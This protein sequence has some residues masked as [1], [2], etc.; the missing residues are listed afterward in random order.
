[1]QDRTIDNALLALRKQII[2]GGLEGRDQVEALL[3]LRGLPIPRTMGYPACRGCM[4]RLILDALSSGPKPLCDVVAHVV[5]GR[6]ELTGE[7]AYHRTA[8]RLYRMKLAGLVW[9]E[10]RIWFVLPALQ[11]GVV[12]R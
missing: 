12:R 3:W 4:K 2:R 11:Q 7:T 8:Q 9:R 1:M 5:A 6:P 10:G